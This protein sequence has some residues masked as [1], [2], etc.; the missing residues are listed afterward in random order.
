MDEIIH[1]LSYACELGS[2]IAGSAEGPLILH[3]SPYQ[4]L[5]GCSLNWQPCIQSDVSQRKM[6]AADEIARCCEQLA[7]Q[8]QHCVQHQQ[9]FLALGGD[10]SI[11]IGT[12]SGVAA[13]ANKPLGLIWVD[14]HMDSHTPET[15]DTQNIHGMPVAALMGYGDA[16]LTRIL[17]EQPKLAP[18]HIV[19]IGIR[20][21]ESGEQQF[22]EKLGVKIFYIEDVQQQG[23]VAVMQQA[24]DYLDAQNVQLGLTIDLDGLDPNDAPGVSLPV[25]NG[26]LAA[27]LLQ[28]CSLLKQNASL[29]G[30]E[31]AEF[32]PR[33]DRDHIT[34]R[35]VFEIASHIL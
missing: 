28:G 34:E 25:K 27:D 24:I 9:R 31:I 19:F 1:V 11:A 32:T 16:R 30:I 2:T 26:I 17:S 14:A 10:H 22:L 18:E 21:F 12:W 8:T 33:N 5:V 6:A 3:Q 7:L 20:S 23:F 15:S 29:C 4:S 35:L 13:A